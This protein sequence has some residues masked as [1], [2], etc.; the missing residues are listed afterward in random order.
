MQF[1][2]FTN[3]IYTFC[4]WFARLAYLNLLWICFTLIGGIILGF[5]PATIALLATLRQFL[6]GNS[7]AIRSTFWGYY[8]EEFWRSNRLGG[9]VASICLLLFINFFFLQPA[10]SFYVLYTWIIMCCLSVLVICY[11]LALYVEFE[12]TLTMLIKNGILLTLYNP[13]PSLFIIF[14]FSAVYF[15]ITN[16]PGTGFFFSA[17]I[18]GLVVLSSANLAYRKVE[19]KQQNGSPV[20]QK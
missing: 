10:D 15:V 18:L 20:S 16:I 2:T 6:K 4:N 11:T 12:Q 3:S 7:P 19:R 8:K 9:L 5:F 1:G 13:V 17:S 14:G